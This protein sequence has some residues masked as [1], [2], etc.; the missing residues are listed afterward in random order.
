MSV[1][2]RLMGQLKSY[3]N[4]QS[5]ITVEAGL[6]VRETLVAL[7]IQSDLVTGVFVNGDLQSKD[8]ILQEEDDVKL[9]AI[10]SGG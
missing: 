7:K 8:Y 1:H 6:T 3:L 9:I 4:N 10:M 5:E 2:I